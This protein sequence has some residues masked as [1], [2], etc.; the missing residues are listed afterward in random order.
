[1]KKKVTVVL[2]A[3]LALNPV[4]AFACGC[5]LPFIP[6][7]APPAPPPAAAAAAPQANQANNV[8]QSSTRGHHGSAA[9]AYVG[10]AIA[11]SA[12]SLIVGGAIVGHQQKRE[13][14]QEEALGTVA[15]CF[16]PIV[17]GLIV[18]EMLRKKPVA[19]R[20]VRARG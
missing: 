3:F 8:N 5:E 6:A 9:A 15:N 7:P 18:Q 4:V 14:T 13:L 20:A 2:A 12:V 10:G 16:L 17:G 11:C 1:M 19:Q